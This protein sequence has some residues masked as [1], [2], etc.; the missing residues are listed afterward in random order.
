MFHTGKVILLKASKVEIL[1]GKIEKML[2]LQ[3]SLE[4]LANREMEK[5]DFS[6]AQVCSNY[7]VLHTTQL[8]LL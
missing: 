7:R 2:K 6:F 4:M 8:L 5:S 3:R 1:Q